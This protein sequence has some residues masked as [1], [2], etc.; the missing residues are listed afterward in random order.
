MVYNSYFTI[1]LLPNQSTVGITFSLQL[2]HISVRFQEKNVFS[3]RLLKDLIASPN[4]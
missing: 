2:L 3:K 4:L 1:L